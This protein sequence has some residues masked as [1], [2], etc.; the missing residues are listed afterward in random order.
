MDMDQQE[1]NRRPSMAEVWMAAA[2]ML[3]MRS[4]CSKLQVGCI[5]TTKDLRHVLGNGY[6]GGARKANHTCKPKD[7]DCLHAED[8]AISDAG[9]AHKDKVVFV[10]TFPCKACVYR[11]INSGIDAIYYRNE[12]K[13]NSHHWQDFPKLEKLLADNKVSIIKI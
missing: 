12:Y 5:V 3:S 11:M 8:N 9:S 6:N 4:Q 10:T 1:T 13:E 7:C 2:E